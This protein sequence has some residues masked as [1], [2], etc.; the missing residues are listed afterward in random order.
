MDD[1]LYFQCPDHIGQCFH[2]YL[3]MDYIGTSVAVVFSSDPDLDES[4]VL[5]K[6]G[7]VRNVRMW[8]KSEVDM[9]IRT[10]QQAK[11]KAL[12]Y[13]E[14]S[15]SEQWLN[16]CAQGLK[17]PGPI[18]FSAHSSRSFSSSPESEPL[19][20]KHYTMVDTLG[21]V[22]HIPFEA[23]RND[24]LEFLMDVDSLEREEAEAQLK[25]KE[26]EGFATI[27]TW[28]DEQ[29]DLRDALRL[30]TLVPGTDA[31]AAEI[32]IEFYMSQSSNVIKLY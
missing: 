27:E 15:F 24:Y 8:L 29:F 18:E 30:G 6:H 20:L 11:A 32:A 28:Y 17:N 19:S 31:Y 9:L 23:V 12:V 1:R 10:G 2:Y 16:L 26:D 14:G 5:L 7:E 3:C 25:S 22:F 4:A 21:R 13:R